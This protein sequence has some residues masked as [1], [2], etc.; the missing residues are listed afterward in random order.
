MTDGGS[1]YTGSGSYFSP[2][3]STPHPRLP[4]TEVIPELKLS[5]GVPSGGWNPY[6]LDHWGPVGG[7]L[8]LLL[9]YTV[10]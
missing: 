4:E 9:I 6:A 1:P 10:F 2:T 3:Q 8:C 5:L 7:L